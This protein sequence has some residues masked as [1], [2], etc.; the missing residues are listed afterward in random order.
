[1]TP[2]SA[3]L[4]FPKDKAIMP[5]IM[6]AKLPNFPFFYRKAKHYFLDKT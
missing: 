3:E 2:I 1:M 6:T 4:G 5:N